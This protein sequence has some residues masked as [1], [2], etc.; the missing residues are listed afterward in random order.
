MVSELC[1][2][3][4]NSTSEL[5]GEP[6]NWNAEQFTYSWLAVLH[7]QSIALHQSNKTTRPAVVQ[8]FYAQELLS[9]K[10]TPENFSGAASK[11]L[12]KNIVYYWKLMSSHFFFQFLVWFWGDI[13]TPGNPYYRVLP[14]LYLQHSFLPAFVGIKFGSCRW[15]NKLLID[16]ES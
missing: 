11:N 2:R 15:V 14:W 1:F 13:C 3:P 9:K 7:N 6:H 5:L 12:E 16:R 8:S 10:W 4:I